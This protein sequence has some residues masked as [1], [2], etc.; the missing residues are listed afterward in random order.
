MENISVLL[1]EEDQAQI[2]IVE[3]ILNT[4]GIK[5]HITNDGHSAL[6]LIQNERNSYDAIVC[7]I[8]IPSVHHMDFHDA[9][10]LNFPVVGVSK[11][12]GMNVVNKL[13]NSC[14]AFIEI[15]DISELLVLAIEKAIE[16][17]R[18]DEE[19]KQCA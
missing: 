15:F 1:I 10:S 19:F 9:F 4:A 2:K 3:N 12:V 17:R 7:N 16:R 5:A 13:A 8:D 14:D 18:E 6:D 11:A